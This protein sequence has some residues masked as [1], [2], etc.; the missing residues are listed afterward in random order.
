MNI[1]F[2]ELIIYSD[3]AM[4]IFEIYFSTHAFFV[5]LYDFPSKHELGLC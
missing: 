2:F 1:Y 5:N 4:I 3:Y